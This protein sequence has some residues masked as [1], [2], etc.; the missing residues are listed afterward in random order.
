MGND[1][2]C[3]RCVSSLL[4]LAAVSLIVGCTVDSTGF[5]RN[6]QIGALDGSATMR[7]EVEVY[8]GP[9]SKEPPIQLGELKGII[10]D[11]KRA[12][13]ILLGNMNYSRLR[14]GCNKLDQ[15]DPVGTITD[16]IMITTGHLKCNEIQFKFNPK[17][18]PKKS[19][20]PE[21]SDNWPQECNS[22]RHLFRDVVEGLE[23]QETVAKIVSKYKSG[24]THNGSCTPPQS[25][26]P[27]NELKSLTEIC[28]FGV[29]PG[30]ESSD[31][32]KCAL[33][34][35]EISAYGS[36]LKRRAAYWAAEHVATSPL[37][38]R[39]RI[40]MTNFAQF[41][42]EYGNQITS[43]ADALLKQSSGARGIEILREQLPNSTYL[44]D[45]APTGYLNL[46]NWND[47]AV[48]FGRK[49]TPAERI[50]MVEHLVSDNYW[51]R[52]N[53]V[54]AAGQGNVSMAFVKDDVGNWNL[55]SFDNSP[56]ELLKAYKDLGL[57]AVRATVQLA[58]SSS[59][60]PA[61]KNA[62]NFANQIAL[63]STSGDRVKETEDRL[64]VLR[65][66]TARLIKKVGDDQN[67]QDAKLKKDIADLN[68]KIGAGGT[69][70]G[71]KAK[72]K[73]AE[74]ELDNQIKVL[75]DLETRVTA[76]G[77]KIKEL[78]AVVAVLTEKRDSNIKKRDDLQSTDHREASSADG[79]VATPNSNEF[80]IKALNDE[81][82][83]SNDQITTNTKLLST[84]LQQQSTDLEKLEDEK[85][86]QVALQR[87]VD[88][89]KKELDDAVALKNVQQAQ[90][91]NL[92]RDTAMQIQQL[93]DLHNAIV[94]RMA[95]AAAE[96][97]GSSAP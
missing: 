96:A 83:R 30:A 14:M 9:L 71:L 93:L 63:G 15:C 73:T 3:G 21:K 34:L 91:N 55:K 19:D 2:P 72:H 94:A 74:F 48:E 64:T 27:Q 12:L 41:A 50:R 54:F 97:S 65:R 47:A 4:A 81:I 90:R 7:V 26:Q 46:Y 75:K 67:K 29:P 23:S 36:Y 52:I 49:T 69:D 13:D 61:T 92:T 38:K 85:A 11:S 24:M 10:N 51:S 42:A 28:G 59:G 66:E 22:L 18:P 76:R 68:K 20:E 6:S 84:E 25:C 86:K 32:T 80:H 33:G 16:N 5:D 58:G 53:T 39:L 1:R 62:L 8:K 60:L 79:G 77:G 44:R 88:K 35:G 37:S 87:A 40:E 31:L 45:S 57:A 17:A 43:R 82:A 70:T 78:Q 95:I 89:A 56:G